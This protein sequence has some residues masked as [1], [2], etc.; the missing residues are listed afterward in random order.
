MTNP[1]SDAYRGLR[2]AI[3]QYGEGGYSPETDVLLEAAREKVRQAEKLQ[4]PETGKQAAMERSRLDQVARER[5]ALVAAHRDAYRLAEQNKDQATASHRQAV[6]ELETIRTAARTEE[7]S[8]EQLSHLVSAAEIAELKLESVTKAYREAKQTVDYDVADALC[9]LAVA[10]ITTA[11]NTVKSARDDLVVAANAFHDSIVNHASE[12]RRVLRPLLA[13]APS[14]SDRFSADNGRITIDQKPLNGI[15][16]A[17]AVSCCVAVAPIISLSPDLGE[18]SEFVRTT[19]RYQNALP[20]T[21]MF[22]P[23]DTNTDA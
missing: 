7:V 13:A 20:D 5:P 11:T 9:D 8:A 2:L 22:S 21:T 6:S 18:L 1:L 12:R 23:I 4:E 17:A 3:G 16:K 19:G 15:E 10:A 14:G